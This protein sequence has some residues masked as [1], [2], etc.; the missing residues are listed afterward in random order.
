MP[1]IAEKLGLM[2]V[3][4]IKVCVKAGIESKA[5]PTMLILVTHVSCHDFVDI[6]E[7]S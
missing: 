4:A 6:H 3:Q 7:I 2:K 5:L 1:G